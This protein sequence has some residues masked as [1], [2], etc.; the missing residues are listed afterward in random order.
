MV[1]TINGGRPQGGQD[2]KGSSTHELIFA[3]AAAT[4]ALLFPTKIA[5]SIMTTGRFK[6]V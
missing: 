5:L 1:N 2:S 6:K 3:L 4:T